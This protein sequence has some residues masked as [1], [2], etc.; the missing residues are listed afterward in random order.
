MDCTIEILILKSQIV[1]LVI[2]HGYL[3]AFIF[4]KNCTC[5]GMEVHIRLLMLSLLKCSFY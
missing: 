3:N 1:K 2:N 5:I 4:E